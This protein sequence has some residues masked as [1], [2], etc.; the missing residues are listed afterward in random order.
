[1]YDSIIIGSGPAGVT[2]SLYMIRA[3]L[4]ILVIS[5]NQTALNKA[6]HIENYYGFEN[7]ISGKELNDIGIKQA[8]NLGVQFLEKEVTSIKY[9][10]EGYEVIVANQGIDEKYL[11]KTIVL[12]TYLSSIP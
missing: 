10:E 5:K 8:Q 12:D 1:M 4:K 11:A 7:G 3:G 9:A 2:A 6:E